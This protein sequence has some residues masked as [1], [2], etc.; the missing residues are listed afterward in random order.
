M[1]SG[2]YSIL[3]NVNGKQYIGQ[4]Y[5]CR[6][7]KVQHY[8][9]LRCG[10][11]HNPHLQRSFNKYGEDA[12]SFRILEYCGK[13]E[14]NGLE[15]FYIEKFNSDNPRMGY[16]ETKGGDNPPVFF[17]EENN[18]YRQDVWVCE[19]DICN[20]YLDNHTIEQ[21]GEKFNGSTTIIRSILKK[22]S[23][24]TRT[25][26]DVKKR[27]DVWENEDIICKSYSED[28]MSLNQIGE[29]YGVSDGVIRRILKSNNIDI[30]SNLGNCR[31]YDL[32]K[33]E[34]QICSEYKKGH[35]LNQ[36]SHDYNCSPVTIKRILEKNNIT[37][38]NGSEQMK[39]KH[40]S[41]NAWRNE[42]VICNYYS[43]G[44]MSL[45]Q[46]AEKFNTS[47][48]TIQKILVKN[49][50]SIRNSE[51]IQ[52]MNGIA[53]VYKR[54]YKEKWRWK[55]VYDENGKK[56]EITS[57][58]PQKLKEKVISKGFDW[59]ILDEKQAKENNLL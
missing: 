53:H 46:I 59:I 47:R 31:R 37:I 35:S 52:K 58:N 30:R 50:I 42:R 48:S 32:W 7:R 29:Q 57:V 38:V 19:E 14:L 56:R 54:R 21:T 55:Y 39:W 11:H 23:I 41:I 40:G 20:Y 18:R 10:R 34:S 16:N 13:S 25:N 17:R 1:N 8:S 33:Q 28:Y 15:E 6:Q 45:N 2:I 9:D 36:I 12:F 24:P 5:N 27:W 51:N 44:S 49:N 4:A 26:S 43:K 3:N 22:N